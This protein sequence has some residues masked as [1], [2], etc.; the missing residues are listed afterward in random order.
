MAQSNHERVGRALEILNKGLQPFIERE[1]PTATVEG[2]LLLKMYAL[3][4][5][6]RQGNFTRVALYENDLAMLIHD[7]HPDP[8][9]LLAELSQYVSETDLIAV[10]D[11]IAEIQQRIERFNKTSRES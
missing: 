9:P 11:I 10:R 1:I 6:Y 4:S 2:L 8:D 5:L 3:P 7:Y